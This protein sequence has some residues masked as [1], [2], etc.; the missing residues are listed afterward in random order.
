MEHFLSSQAGIFLTLT[1]C[2]FL[3]GLLYDFFRIVRRVLKISKI[4]TAI[5]DIFYWGIAI[6][7]VF[8]VLMFTNFGQIRGFV[9]LAAVLGVLVYFLSVSP[10][11]L[12]IGAKASQKVV[13]CTKNRAAAAKNSLRQYKKYVMIKTKE[14]VALYKGRKK[15]D[16]ANCK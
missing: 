14:K 3:L 7:F 9:F 5:Q 15:D 1:L 8:V 4:W 10:K 13:D 2:G 6:C 16:K 11:I 12:P